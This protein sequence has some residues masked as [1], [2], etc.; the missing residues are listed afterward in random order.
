MTTH[1][2]SESDAQAEE[3]YRQLSKQPLGDYRETWRALA[4]NKVYRSE[5]QLAAARLARER[6]LPPDRRDDVVQ[7]ALVILAE[8][9]RRGN[10]GFDPRY[11]KEHLLPWLRAVVRV[12]CRY[13]LR[14]QGLRDGS[15]SPVDVECAACHQP[16]AEWQAELADAIQSLDE[17]LR[18][19]LIAFGQLGSIQAVAQQL[20]LSVT[21]AW[22]RFGA[23]ARQVRQRCRPFAETGRIAG[24]SRA[25]Q[26]W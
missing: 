24:V 17:P 2:N 14:R 11:G 12:H 1:S 8:Y 20:G 15:A 6:H 3:I 16:N 7:E 4:T 18:E 13:A 21:T 25:V 22:R 23:A 9:L 5:L 26:K 10:L 19:I